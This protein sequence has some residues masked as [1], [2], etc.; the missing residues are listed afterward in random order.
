M[1]QLVAYQ[2]GLTTKR[3]LSLILKKE[4]KSEKQKSFKMKELN[5]LL[6]RVRH[7]GNSK[8]SRK[9]SDTPYK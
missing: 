2:A 7:L 1:P 9:T 3:I 6:Q 8:E 5:V 4:I